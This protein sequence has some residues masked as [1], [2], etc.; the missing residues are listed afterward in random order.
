MMKSATCLLLLAAGSLQSNAQTAVDN[1]P[2]AD[3][4]TGELYE[5]GSNDC[6]SSLGVSMAMSLVYPSAVSNSDSELQIRTVLGYPSDSQ[7]TLLWEDAT[8]SLTSR[9]QGVCYNEWDGG[10]QGEEPTVQIANSVFVHDEITLNATYEGVVGDYVQQLDFQ[11]PE[12]GSIVNAWVNQ[13]TNGLIDSLVEEGS[14]EPWIVLIINSIYLKASWTNQ[15]SEDRT[16]ED[17]FFPTGLSADGETG[18]GSLAHFM[19]NVEYFPYSHDA[20]PGYQILQHTFAGGAESSGLSMIFVLPLPGTTPTTTLVSSQQILGALSQLERTRMAV[21]LPKFKFES[22]YED[23]LKAALQDLGMTSPFDEQLINNLCIPDDTCHTFIDV[24][25]QKTI[26][27]VNEKG[28]EAA[29]V[30]GIGI[31]ATSLPPPFATL[32]MA[33]R[34]FQFFIH[35]QA[36]NVVLFEG[37]VG[38]PEIPQG[39]A[40]PLQAKHEDA[41]FWENTFFVEATMPV[42]ETMPATTEAPTN[43]DT[44]MESLN[45]TVPEDE[46]GSDIEMNNQTNAEQESTNSSASMTDEGS[47]VED[48][49]GTS[50]VSITD[51]TEDTEL[52]SSAA[53]RTDGFLAGLVM[54]V[55]LYPF[56]A[57]A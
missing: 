27:D 40:A 5:E 56:L 16:N 51:T 8:A 22:E 7:S 15:F 45:T 10:C 31:S 50:T 46:G 54:L 17:V 42:P 30:T 33:D 34:P 6:T 47:P 44:M 38:Q 28:V 23:T 43:T 1:A 11:D 12:A 41:D 13:S 48:T 29:A 26:I 19:H 36:E 20:I 55:A 4:L 14:L 39:S 18:T 9:Y 24:I 53:W 49:G 21:A 57:I 52:T 2:F 32:F 35:D 3:A 37:R 25:I